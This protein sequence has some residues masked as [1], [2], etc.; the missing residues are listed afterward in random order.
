M[1]WKAKNLGLEPV[2]QAI[3]LSTS[4]VT[5]YGMWLTGN[6]RWQGWAVGL[7]NQGLWLVFIITFGAWGL[8]PLSVALT[9]IYTRNLV[10]WR[11]E[12]SHGT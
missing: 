5:L 6:K 8:L 9:V 12:E 11:A 4:V 7:G 2:R 1:L 3:A 10:R